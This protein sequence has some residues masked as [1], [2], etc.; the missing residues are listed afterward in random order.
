MFI[1]ALIAAIETG[2]GATRPQEIIPKIISVSKE[3]SKDVAQIIKEPCDDLMIQHMTLGEFKNKLNFYESRGDYCAKNKYGF[4]GAYQFSGYMIRTFGKTSKK[5]FL[6][7]ES[8][9]E[10]AMSLACA[11]YLRHIYKMHYD[12]LVGRQI[13]GMT[14]TM[15]ALMLGVHFSPTYLHRWIKSGGCLNG[16]DAN[17]SLQQYMTKFEVKNERKLI[18][19]RQP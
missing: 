12:T 2:T 6:E 9:Q 4:V 19:E 7:N 17:L 1:L 8:V 11:N 5:H 16:R 18:F 15:E 10:N 3:V 13:N 14:I